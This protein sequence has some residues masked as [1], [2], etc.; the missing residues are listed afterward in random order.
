MSAENGARPLPRRTRLAGLAGRF[1]IGEAVLGLRARRW[2]PWKPLIVVAYHRVN[3][4]DAIA[5]LDPDLID[6]TP[7]AFESQ[8][9]FF[10]DHFQGVT[11]Q[12]VIDAI[13]GR[14]ALPPNPLL[15]TFDDGYLDNFR[16]ALPI[17]QRTGM[18]AVFFV[19]TGYMN[20]RRLFWWDR[21][22]ITIHEAKVDAVTLDYPQPQMLSLA[23]PEARAAAVQ[24]ANRIVKDTFALDL[25]RFLDGLTRACGVAWSPEREAALAAD[26]IMGW[27][28][29]AALHAAGMQVQSH[30][31][32]H[33]VIET[34][35]E[36]ELAAELAGART[37]LE[38]RLR[39]EVR[40]IAY[41][42]GRSIADR[43]HIRKA[44]AAAG[45]RIGFTSLN[46]T[47][48]VGASDVYDLR[49]LMI[50]RAF[51]DDIV[52]GFAALPWL[53]E[54]PRKRRSSSAS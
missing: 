10:R 4:A 49:R 47:N 16:H 27:E 25:E 24:R 43:G 5:G 6:A 39:T 54:P 22:W 3:H 17:L 48:A 38:Q 8:M 36:G 2:W 28:E 21:I 34:L 15:V 31:R 14:A 40:S 37:D 35:P 29:V 13:D 7:E 52:R 1:K 20:K 12:E 23:T 9:R 44:L 33:R 32:S 45:Y 30:T 53:S 11:V 50:D 19:S 18:R 41:P 51:S 42:V 46:G 26:T